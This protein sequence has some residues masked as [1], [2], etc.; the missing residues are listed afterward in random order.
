MRIMLIGI[1]LV[2][3]A[4]AD[5]AIASEVAEATKTSKLAPH[6]VIDTE[7]GHVIAIFDEGIAIKTPRLNCSAF[8]DCIEFCGEV[9]Q[10]GQVE[11]CFCEGQSFECLDIGDPPVCEVLKK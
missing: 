1:F 10:T 8:S 9:C 5:Q 7:S 3:A 6:T 11:V 4:G 2:L